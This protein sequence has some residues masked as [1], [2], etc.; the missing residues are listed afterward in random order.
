MYPNLVRELEQVHLEQVWVSDITYI[1]LQ[2]A[3][4]SVV[5]YRW[6]FKTDSAL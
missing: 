1:T 6:L 4:L 5:G 2:K 3:L